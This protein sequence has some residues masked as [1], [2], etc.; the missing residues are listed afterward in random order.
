MSES[1]K[2]KS[3]SPKPSTSKES[4]KGAAPEESARKKSSQQGR[5]SWGTSFF[6]KYENI[7]T[8][9]RGSSIPL[10]SFELPAAKQAKYKRLSDWHKPPDKKGKLNIV[11][12]MERASISN[13]SRGDSSH[14]MTTRSKTRCSLQARL[15]PSDS[16][17]PSSSD[18][19]PE[20]SVRGKLKDYKKKKSDRDWQN[21]K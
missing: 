21:R 5:P 6:K 17:L 13:A 20:G 8:R 18:E 9:K 7:D 4:K 16:N 10:P 11:K 1:D 2:E 3:P 12:K 15:P 19:E 14:S